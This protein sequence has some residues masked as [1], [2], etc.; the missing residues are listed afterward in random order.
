MVARH[1]S[2]ACR[3]GP[4]VVVTEPVNSRRRAAGDD[5]GHSSTSPKRDR[6]RRRRACVVVTRRR[7]NISWMMALKR[8]LGREAI[9]RTKDAWRVTF[10]RE[11]QISSADQAGAGGA[12]CRISMRAGD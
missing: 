2:N 10:Y 1:G 9:I 6:S 5:D 3:T 11:L 7:Q 4:H 12:A 8:D